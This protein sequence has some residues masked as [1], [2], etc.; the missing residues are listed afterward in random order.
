M[1]IWEVRSWQ[2]CRGQSQCAR[3]SGFLQWFDEG[4]SLKISFL[5]SDSMKEQC[6]VLESNLLFVEVRK[7]V[8]VVPDSLSM[9][10]GVQP[11]ILLRQM[12][13]YS[14]ILMLEAML[15][16]SLL[17]SLTC[18]TWMNTLML[19]PYLYHEVLLLLCHAIILLCALSS[20]AAIMMMTSFMLLLLMTVWIV[21]CIDH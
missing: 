13:F 16:V 4:I 18:Y 3:F 7:F 8:P 19:L 20:T 9:L 10:H 5:S 12:I 17:W 2:C 14:Q 15:R 11:Y 6:F 1:Q 21:C